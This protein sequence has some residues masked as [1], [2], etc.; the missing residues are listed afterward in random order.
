MN[1][2]NSVMK[3]YLTSYNTIYQFKLQNLFCM[4]AKRYFVTFLVANLKFRHLQGTKNK[5]CK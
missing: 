3:N 1:T 5:K 4:C 2:F